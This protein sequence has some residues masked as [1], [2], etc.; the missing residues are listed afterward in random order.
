MQEKNIGEGKRLEETVG[1][2][3]KKIIQLL[4]NILRIAK[5]NFNYVYAHV[6]KFPRILMAPLRDSL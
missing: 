6:L 3:T 4:L 5:R 2:S 1:N